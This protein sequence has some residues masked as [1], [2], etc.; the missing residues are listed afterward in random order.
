MTGSHTTITGHAI[1]IL[2]VCLIVSIS[3]LG[4]RREQQQVTIAFALL[5]TQVELKTA[6]PGQEI[7]LETISDII[8]DRL[9]LI[10][11]HS[12]IT[13]HVT[14][15]S[16]KGKNAGGAALALVLD[17]IVRTDGTK[18]D[19]QA[20][21]AAVAAPNDDSLASDPTY[22]MMRSNEPKMSARPSSTASSGE[23]SAGSKA[24]STA[25]VATAE[26]KGAIDRMLLDENSQGA[27]GYE[28]LSITWSLATPPPVTI[29]TT[30]KKNMKLFT[31]TQVLLRMVPPRLQKGAYP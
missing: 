14:Q 19:L 9:V 25:A 30:K 24:S 10:P 21:I 3:I 17:K 22:G 31:R 20:I 5:T 28:G 11:A 18:F 13:G 27:I 15:V 29:F 7:I 16:A 1:G 8:V 26:L 2:G 6:A 12:K 4:Q 23:L